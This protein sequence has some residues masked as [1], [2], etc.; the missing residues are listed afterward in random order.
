MSRHF[1]H[2]EL[3]AIESFFNFAILVQY[4]VP[5]IQ[6]ALNSITKIVKQNQW[7]MP[8]TFSLWYSAS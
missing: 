1:F 3:S 7:Q 6:I 2:Q 8:K 4:I 5:R